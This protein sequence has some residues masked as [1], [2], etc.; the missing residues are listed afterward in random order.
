[1]IITE[2]VF[3]PL[4]QFTH[5]GKLCRQNKLGHFPIHAAAFSGAKKSME[6][7]LKKGEISCHLFHCAFSTL[8]QV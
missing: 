7:I 1:M 6:V 5:G 2:N 3:D 4:L 8:K